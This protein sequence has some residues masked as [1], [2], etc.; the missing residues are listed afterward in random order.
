MHTYG[1][2]ARDEFLLETIGS[3]SFAMAVILGFQRI[4]FLE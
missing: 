4:A 2:T 3:E 1:P